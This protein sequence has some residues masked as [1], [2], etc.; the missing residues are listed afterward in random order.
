M[1]VKSISHE[2]IQF[3]IKFKFKLHYLN[4]FYNTQYG[5]ETQTSKIE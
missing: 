1:D 2:Y 4:L 3:D 5:I